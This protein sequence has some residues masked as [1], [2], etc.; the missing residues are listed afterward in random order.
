FLAHPDRELVLAQDEKGEIARQR[1]QEA[2]RV[3]VSSGMLTQDEIDEFGAAFAERLQVK[4]GPDGLWR[5]SLRD[6]EMYV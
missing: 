5:F 3:A 1:A 4:Q 2:V 6:G